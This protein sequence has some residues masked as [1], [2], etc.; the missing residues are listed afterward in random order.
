[1]VLQT[2]SAKS[3]QSSTI[4]SDLLCRH[5]GYNLRGLT[6][7]GACPEC[8]RATLESLPRF[9]KDSDP[10]YLR[11]IGRG[12]VL[13]IVGMVLSAVAGMLLS[14]TLPSLYLALAPNGAGIILAIAPPIVMLVG[15]WK[16][17]SVDPH[18]HGERNQERL[19]KL[20]RTTAMTGTVIE[21]VEIGTSRAFMLPSFGAR[22]TGWI[23]YPISTIALIVG[24][25][26]T[27]AYLRTLAYRVPD[28]VLCRRFGS[29]RWGFGIPYSIFILFLA[30]GELF[31]V[32]TMLADIED[33]FMAI[34]T[35]NTVTLAITALAGM[36]YI[37]A[38]IRLRRGVGASLRC[39]EAGK[40]QAQ[41]TIA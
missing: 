30:C 3:I 9:L 27:L 8:G 39:G 6:L 33:Q 1:M 41:D 34:L 23:L 4:E 19:R 17:T 12:A 2:D 22:M 32:T 18:G 29:L 35:V 15:L 5:C 38:L 10:A 11:T 24:V 37:A 20:V 14:L 13:M 31:L 26:A 7:G 21:L 40:S 36:F 16:I 25:F 28:Y